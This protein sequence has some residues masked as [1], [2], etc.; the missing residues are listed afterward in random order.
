MQAATVLINRR[1]LRHNLQRLRELAPA[2]KLVAVVLYLGIGPA[3]IGFYAWNQGVSRLGASGAMVFYNTMPLY[4]ALLS[5]LFLGEPIGAA[6]IVG[7]LMIISGGL[8][9][10]R[11][12]QAT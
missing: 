5:M 12:R 8:W 10:A 11:K 7:G 9:A 6:H 4:G 3:A 2:S 1:A